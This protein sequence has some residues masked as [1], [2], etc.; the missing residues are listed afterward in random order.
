[1]NVRRRDSDLDENRLRFRLKSTW[2]DAV[3]DKVLTVTLIAAL[4]LS[5]Q[6][7]SVWFSQAGVNDVGIFRSTQQLCIFH[8]V[9]V[10]FCN[11]G[12]LFPVP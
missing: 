5:S 7:K 2:V 8:V 12:S 6:Q 3:E 1:M 11:C 4:E 10:L 9:H